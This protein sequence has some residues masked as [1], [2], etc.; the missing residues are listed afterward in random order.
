MEWSEDCQK[1]PP[2]M[3]CK[4]I[5]LKIFAK[6]TGKHLCQSLLFHKVADLSGLQGLE[7]FRGNSNPAN[8]YLFEVSNRNTRKKCEICSKLDINYVVLNV[9]KVSKVIRIISNCIIPADTYLFRVNKRNTR[10]KCEICSKLTIKTL[11][12]CH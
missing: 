8:I 11:K 1:Q 4:K 6:L 9:R 7:I 12:R 2:E 10:K 3:F 5:V